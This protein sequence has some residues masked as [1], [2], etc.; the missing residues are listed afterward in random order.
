VAAA[1][2]AA[3]VFCGLVRSS[4]GY[5]PVAV[6]RGPVTCAQ[7]L[8]VIAA[9]ERA[10]ERGGRFASWQ[11]SRAFGVPRRFELRCLRGGAEIWILERIP[12]AAR[13]LSSPPALGRPFAR[14]LHARLANW[15]FA[16][17]W[18]R[19]RRRQPE[20]YARP[21]GG[22]WLDLGPTRGL[23]CVIDIP[24]EVLRAWR[25]RQRSPAGG[26]FATG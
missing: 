14:A 13:V 1:L 23:V 3:V 18:L 24:A 11:C 5:D 4:T 12:V 17:A 9:V 8:R 16:L 10:S 15:E 20:A 25:L 21:R 7:A 26:C 22:R 2:V 6:V 19:F